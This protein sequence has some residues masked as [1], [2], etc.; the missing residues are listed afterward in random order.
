MT[1]VA[2]RPLEF[3]DLDQA[4]RLSTTAGWNQQLD[5]WRLFLRI[6]RAGAFAAVADGRIVGTAIGVDYGGFA[7]IAMMLVDPAYRGCGLGGRLLEAALDSVPAN[8]P[9]RLD[10]T[11]LG[12]PLYRRYGFEVE[13]TLSRF[14]VER[15]AVRPIGSGPVQSMTRADLPLAI[16]RDRQV[17][18]GTRAAVLEWAF[19]SAPNYAH[20]ALT[21]S[22]AIQY[23]FG[24]HGRLFD[25]IGPVVADDAVVAQA[26]VGAAGAAANGRSIAVDA[27]DLQTAFGAGLREYGFV[28]ERPFFRMC[29]S[30]GLVRASAP[31]EYAIFGPEFG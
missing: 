8:L 21:S 17:F 9:V 15:M 27:F 13:T 6:A 1:A 18:G 11:P 20:V 16:E 2:I 30:R 7:W 10:A 25:Q 14:V 19:R 28:V 29:L 31:G 4:L 26:L 24:R 12:R 23:C 22:G 5:D 3:D